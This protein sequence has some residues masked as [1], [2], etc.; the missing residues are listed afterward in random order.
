MQFKQKGMV[1]LVVSLVLVIATT[2][3]TL[4][5]TR[6]SVFEIQT[7]TNE[8]HHKL[9]FEAAQFGLQQGIA[10][11]EQNYALVNNSSVTGGW[12]NGTP[13]WTACSGTD[14][15]IP[16]GD[17]QTAIYG[18]EMLVYQNVPNLLTLSTFP[19]ASFTVH[20][21]TENDGGTNSPADKALIKVISVGS[22]AQGTAQTIVQQSVKGKNLLY[23]IAPS[24]LNATG[25][26]SLTGNFN[27]WGNM[28]NGS[29]FTVWSASSV[30]PMK[31]SS[32]TYDV[33]V[34]G[35][36]YPNNSNVLSQGSTNAGDVVENDPGFPSDL[37]FYFFGVPK[38]QAEK[39]KDISKVYANCSNLGANSSGLIWITG[40]CKISGSNGGQIGSADLPVMLV[41]TGEMQVS[42]NSHIYGGLYIR[43]TSPRIK[44]TGTIDVHG[45]IAVDTDLELGAGTFNLTYDEDVLN[46]LNNTGGTLATIPGS[47]NDAL[48]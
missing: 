4:M 30:M 2:I 9:A 23:N 20:Y 7:Q 8:Y 29:P 38:A 18:N 6:S 24:P 1:I 22:A 19:Q 48:S 14:T 27:A 33:S 42:G 46:N 17:G 40:D 12:L 41:V 28:Y 36:Q 43:E 35:G 37:F 45:L 16:C 15:S 34:S 39:I 3:I 44:L 31:G 11:L 47:W 21:L 26:V 10:Y 5:G 25:N 32:A 13:N